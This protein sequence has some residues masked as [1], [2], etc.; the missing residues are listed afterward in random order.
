MDYTTKINMMYAK[1]AK[2]VDKS[3]PFD[4]DIIREEIYSHM[5][6]LN[7]TNLTLDAPDF[8]KTY[9]FECDIS[10]IKLNCFYF[11]WRKDTYNDYLINKL[12]YISPLEKEIKEIEKFL[13][14]EELPVSEEENYFYFNKNGKLNQLKVFDLIDPYD[15]NADPTSFPDSE[16]LCFGD[17]RDELHN[18]YYD[19]FIKGKVP[20]DLDKPL[21]KM[22]KEEKEMFEIF[23]L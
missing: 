8:L 23:F 22:S 7:E 11:F 15:E 13:K 20:S 2:M 9:N 4:S 1:R 12:C 18:F 5:E 19:L 3:I 6:S 14:L 17:Y 10:N 21:N 16:D